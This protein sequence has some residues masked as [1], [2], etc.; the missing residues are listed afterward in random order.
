[1]IS[2]PKCNMCVHNYIFIEL[3]SSCGRLLENIAKTQFWWIEPWISFMVHL[4]VSKCLVNLK[5]VAILHWN[6]NIE[7]FMSFTFFENHSAILDNSSYK[8][9]RR[10]LSPRLQKCMGQRKNQR[11]LISEKLPIVM[12]RGL[13]WKNNRRKFRRPP[14]SSLF[15]TF[16]EPPQFC[17]GRTV[18]HLNCE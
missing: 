5:K 11:P 9:P 10:V 14:L 2:S 12:F 16:R 13:P 6:P 17:K 8:N 15:K 18:V 7:G 4:N 1:M 3:H